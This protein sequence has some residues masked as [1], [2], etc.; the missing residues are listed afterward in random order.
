MQFSTDDGGSKVDSRSSFPNQPCLF[1][2][3]RTLAGSV[4]RHRL[5]RVIKAILGI[6]VRALATWSRACALGNGGLGIPKGAILPPARDRGTGR[7][8]SELIR[9][10]MTAEHHALTTSSGS[11]ASA[12]QQYRTTLI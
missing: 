5:R 9:S 8:I 4:A 11:L 10:Y 2:E 7:E 12:N 1:P 3:V 6:R